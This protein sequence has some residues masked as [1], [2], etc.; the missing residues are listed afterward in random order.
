MSS[1]CCT[2]SAYSFQFFSLKALRRLWWTFLYSLICASLE[3]LVISIKRC[4]NLL[5]DSKPFIFNRISQPGRFLSVWISVSIALLCYGSIIDRRWR[6]SGS[7]SSRSLASFLSIT[8][9]ENLL[10]SSGGVLRLLSSYFSFFPIIGCEAI[11]ALSRSYADSRSTSSGLID[12]TLLCLSSW[13]TESSSPKTFL[14]LEGRSRYIKF[15][16]S[17]SLSSFPRSSKYF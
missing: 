7:A 15:L 17:P 13:A 4:M 12:A 9:N 5:K 3:C 8:G 11:P 14:K 2:I 1:S 6:P 16:F 10:L